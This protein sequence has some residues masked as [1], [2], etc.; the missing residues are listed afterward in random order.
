LIE[1]AKIVDHPMLKTLVH[2]RDLNLA[3][4][5]KYLLTSGPE[6]EVAGHERSY[7]VM[8]REPATGVLHGKINASKHG[9]FE[10]SPNHDAVFLRIVR[11][12]RWLFP[13]FSKGFSRAIQVQRVS[14]G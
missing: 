3:G 6:S 8:S 4:I 12:F 5:K 11:D 9:Y 2:R 7:L 14:E 1:L 13:V 10:A